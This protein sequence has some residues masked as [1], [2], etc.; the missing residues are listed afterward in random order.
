MNEKKCNKFLPMFFRL[1]IPYFTHP[2]DANLIE[3][4]VCIDFN[5]G[6]I[7]FTNPDTPVLYAK[8]Y[9]SS[10][11]PFFDIKEIVIGYIDDEKGLL[12]NSYHYED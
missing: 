2:T 12:G 5:D 1:T 6:V 10:L 7:Y 4:G 11:P 3:T 9:T 8:E